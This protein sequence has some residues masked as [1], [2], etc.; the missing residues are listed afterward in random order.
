[1]FYVCLLHEHMTKLFLFCC[2]G[3]NCMGS[4]L[5]MFGP[6]LWFECIHQTIN[7]V[8]FLRKVVLEIDLRS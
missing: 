2:M 6:I 7:F 5:A 3:S 4:S 8:Y 1:M